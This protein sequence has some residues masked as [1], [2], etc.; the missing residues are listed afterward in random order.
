MPKIDKFINTANS[1]VAAVD[2]LSTAAAAVKSTVGVARTLITN[3]KDLGGQIRL[4]GAN[5]PPGGEVP[6]ANGVTSAVFRS[7]EPKDWR[8]KLSLPTSPAYNS[9]AGLL[10]PLYSTG[11]VVFPNTPSINISHT[12]MYNPMDVVHSNYQ[13]LA[14]ERSKVEAIQITGEFY[15]EDASE[16]QYWVAVMHFLRSVTKMSYGISVDAGA[17]P[18]VVK[19]NGYGDHVFN[20]VP[21]VITGFNLDLP[22]DVDYIS[23]GYTDTA[24]PGSSNITYA[25]V[26]S[27]ISVTVQPLY[28]REQV[29]RFNL[30]DFVKG[31]FVIDNSGFV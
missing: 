20:N 17:P 11:G 31:N 19:L 1:V 12:A 4:A 24:A 21:V 15:C 26:R 28:S 7:E 2:T 23:T 27:S 6:S 10:S 5:L 13:F 22:N 3:A 9:G 16:A 18:P 29:R 30:D 8:V 25:P 14:Y